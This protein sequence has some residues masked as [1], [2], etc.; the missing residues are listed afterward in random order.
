MARQLPS[1][2]LHYHEGCIASDAP[3]LLLEAFLY[4]HKS[5]QGGIVI[6][7]L[8]YDSGSL[9]LIMWETTLFRP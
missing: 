8:R 3:D 9:R 7:K 1:H 6:V 5:W 4:V 2:N